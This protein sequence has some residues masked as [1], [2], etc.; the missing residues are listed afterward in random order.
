[1]PPD[2]GR[3][4]SWAE[5]AHAAVLSGDGRGGGHGR[6]QQRDCVGGVLGVVFGRSRAARGTG[7]GAGAGTGTV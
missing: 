1:M 2:V 5:G 6:E 4:A 7:T 3:S